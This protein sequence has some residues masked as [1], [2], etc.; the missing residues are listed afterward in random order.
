MDIYQYNAIKLKGSSNIWKIAD[1][2][3]IAINNIENEIVELK[4]E[5]LVDT[6][7]LDHYK[8][9]L[10]WEKFEIQSKDKVDDLIDDLIDLSYISTDINKCIIEL[11]IKPKINLNEVIELKHQCQILNCKGKGVRIKKISPI[12]R[13]CDKHRYRVMCKR[14][15]IK[16]IN[17]D[18]IKVVIDNKIFDAL[19]L[20]NKVGCII[21]PT[22]EIGKIYPKWTK[23]TLKNIKK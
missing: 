1:I 20:K 7:Q 8:K 11:S 5:I 10:Q 18:T 16:P 13:L 17:N 9:T 2:I 12:I 19:I 4:N 22:F 3:K 15:L 14:R 6:T 23:Y 21:R